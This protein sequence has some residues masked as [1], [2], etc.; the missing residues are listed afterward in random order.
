MNLTVR[1]KFQVSTSYR[2]RDIKR[3][4]RRFA[5]ELGI[6]IYTYIYIGQLTFI[7]TQIAREL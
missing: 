6:L 7:K 5:E 1:L 2:F 4:K 3:Q